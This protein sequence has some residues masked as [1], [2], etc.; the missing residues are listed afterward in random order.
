MRHRMTD[1]ERSLI[2]EIAKQLS[3]LGKNTTKNT[4]LDQT[5]SRKGF[6]KKLLK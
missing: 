1:K 4:I 6:Y 2:K 3:F 5:F